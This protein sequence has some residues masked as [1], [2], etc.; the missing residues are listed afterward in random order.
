MGLCKMIVRSLV[1]MIIYCI[2]AFSVL[3]GEVVICI[4]EIS[5]RNRRTSDVNERF[6]VLQLSRGR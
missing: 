1:C 3:C 6:W 5:D 2:T 4:D